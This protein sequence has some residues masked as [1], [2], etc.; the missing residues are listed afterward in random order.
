VIC[1]IL[2]IHSY[3]FGAGVAVEARQHVLTATPDPQGQVSFCLQQLP[4]SFPDPHVHA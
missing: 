1:T 4:A 2:I 3:T